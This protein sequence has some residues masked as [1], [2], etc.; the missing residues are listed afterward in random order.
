MGIPWHTF[1]AKST[2]SVPHEGTKISC[3]VHGAVK[4][5]ICC[6]YSVTQLYL[7]L[8]NTVDYSM[9]DFPVLH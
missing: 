1:T 4:I 6:C 3:K 9:P 5:K 8:R 2:G 7:T